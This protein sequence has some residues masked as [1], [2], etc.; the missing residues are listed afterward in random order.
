MGYVKDASN[1]A[2]S[3]LRSVGVSLW[4]IWLSIVA[5]LEEL[6]ELRFVSLQLIF[7]Q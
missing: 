6:I 2:S 1:D 4:P 3:P 5:L 7:D